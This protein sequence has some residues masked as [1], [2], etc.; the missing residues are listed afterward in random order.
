M[1]TEKEIRACQVAA[2]A[3]LD[4]KQFSQTMGQTFDACLE[5]VVM[6][7]PDITWIHKHPDATAVLVFVGIIV[8]GLLMYKLMT[9]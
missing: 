6:S 1:I 7:S 4:N 3:L 2:E 5:R 9:R 8:L